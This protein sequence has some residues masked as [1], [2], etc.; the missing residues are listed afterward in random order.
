MKLPSASTDRLHT[1]EVQVDGDRIVSGALS[2]CLVHRSEAV[3]IGD[4]EDSTLWVLVHD[5]QRRPR[6]RDP[7]IV[8]EMG[9][10]HYEANGLV[11]IQNRRIPAA[12]LE[13]YVYELTGAKVSLDACL[14]FQS[15]IPEG[16]YAGIR[17]KHEGEHYRVAASSY[18]A[19]QFKAMQGAGGNQWLVTSG[20]E[21]DLRRVLVAALM[22]SHHRLAWLLARHGDAVLL[23]VAVLAAAL[24]MLS[25]VGVM[26]ALLS[27]LLLIVYR[28]KQ[29]DIVAYFHQKLVRPSIVRTFYARAR[30]REGST[31]GMSQHTPA[32][33]LL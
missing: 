31:N 24:S 10:V 21:S 13:R 7:G 18:Y 25:R 22:P 29:A 28:C 19:H 33:R 5:E 1:Q 16:N 14:R 8:V 3:S 20:E 32:K 26:V 30:L 4:G 17:I 23:V 2:A 27:V 6:G 11:R 9:I 12:S 15:R